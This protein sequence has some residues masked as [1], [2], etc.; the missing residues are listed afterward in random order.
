MRNTQKFAL[1]CGCMI[2]TGILLTTAGY[3]MGGRVWGITVGNGGLKVNTPDNSRQSTCEYLEET[4]ELEEFTDIDINMDFCDLVIEPSDHFGVSY[5]VDERYHFSAEV[6]KGCLTVTQGTE[7]VLGI[8]SSGNMIFFGTGNIT[9]LWTKD[10]YIKV[11]IPENAKLGDIKIQNGNGDVKGS[12]FSAENLELEMNFGSSELNNISCKTA[13]IVMGNGKLD[14]SD[15]SGETL[16]VENEFGDTDLSEVSADKIEIA[17]GN[18]KLESR[19]L[20]GETLNISQEFGDISLKNVQITGSAVITNG[21]GVCDLV[22]TEVDNLV[23]TSEF[24]DV[25]IVLTDSVSKY[26]L[27]LST[28]FGKVEINKEDMGSAY[29]S[30]EEK[31]KRLTVDCGNGDIKVESET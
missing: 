9:D 1:V 7:P 11:Y 31:E 3:A 15:F 30:L 18:G 17:M 10:Q 23:I 13:G 2:G 6:V 25:N 16:T 26:T 8:G 29:K 28:E 21:N 22:E 5:C 14:L 12:G 24:G 27:K 19:E 4:R 20:K